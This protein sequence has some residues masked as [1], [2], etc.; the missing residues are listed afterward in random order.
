MPIVVIKD[1]KSSN[2]NNSVEDDLTTMVTQP[3]IE[4][5]DDEEYDVKKIIEEEGAADLT[6]CHGRFVCLGAITGFVIQVVSLGAYAVLLLQFRDHIPDASSNGNGAGETLFEYLSFY[7]LSILSQSD[8]V[9]YSMVWLA[10]TATMS[11]AGLSW[12]RSQLQLESNITRRSIFLI[13]VW[14]LVGIVLGAFLSWTFIDA[15][16]AWPINIFPIVATVLVDLV[17]CWLM[18]A[19]FDC[20]RNETEDD[21]D[22]ESDD[23][24]ICC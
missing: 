10:F 17:L 8:L 6:S 1:T 4:Y 24:D 2:N 5:G 23:T 19:C 13:G 16:L 15:Y 7:A 20:G 21:D 18:V 12:I 11:R 9:V 14:Y 3:L 22:D